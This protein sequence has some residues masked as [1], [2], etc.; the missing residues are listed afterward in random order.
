LNPGGGFGVGLEE[1]RQYDAAETE[2]APLQHPAARE[3]VHMLHYDRL[4]RYSQ[5][6]N[7]DSV[8]DMSFNQMQLVYMV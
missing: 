1:V 5:S 6:K 4:Y 3:V 8:P 7:A 2:A